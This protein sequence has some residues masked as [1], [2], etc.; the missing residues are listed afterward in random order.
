MIHFICFLNSNMSLTLLLLLMCS[1]LPGFS[2]ETHKDEGNYTN[3]AR[4]QDFHLKLLRQFSNLLST[5]NAEHEQVKHAMQQEY[6][7]PVAGLSRVLRNAQIKPKVNIMADPTYSKPFRTVNLVL[8]LFFFVFIILVLIYD[9]VKMSK[10][11]RRRAVAVAVARMKRKQAAQRTESSHYSQDVTSL[12]AASSVSAA[13]QQDITEESLIPGTSD[14]IMVKSLKANVVESPTGVTSTVQGKSVLSLNK[15]EP[16]P[17]YVHFDKPQGRS[18]LL[19][20]PEQI[21]STAKTLDSLQHQGEWSGV[22]KMPM[23]LPKSEFA[24]ELINSVT[25]YC[26]SN[27]ALDK[28]QKK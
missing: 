28:N 27:T 8:G 10:N 12:F 21:T 22:F 15:W 23:E 5:D 13:A 17:R 6:E 18:Q 9:T 3:S 19:V 24:A 2:K 7:N 16:L 1:V 25:P 14:I 11:A 4:A 20:H 26:G